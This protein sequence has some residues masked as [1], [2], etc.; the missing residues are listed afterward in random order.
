MADKFVAYADTDTHRGVQGNL[1]GGSWQSNTSV[2][3]S[4]AG[5]LIELRVTTGAGIS[6]SRLHNALEAI[7]ARI[8]QSDEIFG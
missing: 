8:L 3:N 6:R 1:A 4:T 7:K 2:G 5:T